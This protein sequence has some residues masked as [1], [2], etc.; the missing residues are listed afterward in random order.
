MFNKVKDRGNQVNLSLYHNTA[1]DSTW[2][3]SLVYETAESRTSLQSMVLRFRAQKTI[4]NILFTDSY[5][6]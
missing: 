2:N 5:L 1:G 6:I 3:V 4:G